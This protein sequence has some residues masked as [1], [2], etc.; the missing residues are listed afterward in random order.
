[1]DKPHEDDVALAQGGK[2]WG[3]GAAG[4]RANGALGLPACSWAG[5]K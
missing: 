3:L 2:G 4:G 1:M 5:A